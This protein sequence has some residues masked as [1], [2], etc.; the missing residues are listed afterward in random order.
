MDFSTLLI[1]VALLACPIG[2]GAMMWMM[3]KQMGGQKAQSISDAQMTASSTTERLDA[4][5]T[6]RQLLE[7]EIAEATKLVELEARIEKLR[8]NDAGTVSRG[9]I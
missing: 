8:Q 1:F 5:R 3:G 7:T 6:Q 2:M 9:Q 4:L